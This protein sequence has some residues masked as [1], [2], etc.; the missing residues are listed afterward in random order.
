[1][2]VKIFVILVGDVAMRLFVAAR[3]ANARMGAA[4]G[5]RI[6]NGVSAAFNAEMSALGLRKSC[7][8]DTENQPFLVASRCT[9]VSGK[10]YH[11]YFLLIFHAKCFRANFA[12]SRANKGPFEIHG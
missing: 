12:V 8:V 9:S 5:F 4:V 1:M 7:G 3:E 11:A 2:G 6:T 10:I